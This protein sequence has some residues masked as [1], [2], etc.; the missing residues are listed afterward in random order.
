MR[1][2][3]TFKRHPVLAAE[4]LQLRMRVRRSW[5]L[6]VAAASGSIVLTLT[7]VSIVDANAYVV[8]AAG[9]WLTV[10]AL[11]ALSA[12]AF[13]AKRMRRV[14]SEAARSWLAAAPGSKRDRWIATAIRVSWPLVAILGI[15]SML[16]M[17]EAADGAVARALLL[18]LW[19]GAACGAGVGSVLAMKHPSSR[20]EASRYAPR[21]A[22]ATS[23]APSL[24]A[25]SHWPVAQAFA[26]ARPENL[27]VFAAVV[28]L[29]AVQAGSSAV[30]GLLIVASWLLAAYL[31]GLLVAVPEAARAAARWLRSTPLSLKQV[32]GAIGVRALVHQIVG[33]LVAAFAL[34]ALGSPPLTT[35]ALCALWVGVVATVYGAGLV[36][37]LR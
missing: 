36:R 16:A 6:L 17:L 4:W 3:E 29:L 18:S 31:A 19:A 27:R 34:G 7:L 30:H 15:A 2:R 26:W 25:L 23:L 12:L 11:A 24:R 37:A 10:A 20:Y 21:T 1:L 5:L 28:L 8:A 9:S 35:L 13:V 14:R 32:A 22:Q 33:V